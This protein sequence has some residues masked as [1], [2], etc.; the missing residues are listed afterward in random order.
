MLRDTPWDNTRCGTD[1]TSVTRKSPVSEPQSPN[2]KIELIVLPMATSQ[3]HGEDVVTRS[4]CKGQRVR[5]MQAIQSNRDN[6]VIVPSGLL[7]MQPP[8][9][10]LATPSQFAPCSSTPRPQTPRLLLISP[11]HSPPSGTLHISLIC[12]LI[13]CNRL[14]YCCSH[15]TLA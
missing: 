11:C 5:E 10:S 13:A 15:K 14:V 3:G 2:Q 1:P 7:P 6:F 8:Q 12:W 9:R 4:L